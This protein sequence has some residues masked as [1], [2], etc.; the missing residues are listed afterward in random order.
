MKC[1]KCNHSKLSLSSGLTYEYVNSEALKMMNPSVWK[2]IPNL[3]PDSDKIISLNEGGT[4][5]R[6]S[7]IGTKIGIKNLRIKDETRNPTGIFLDRGTATE[8]STINWM[9]LPKDQQYTVAGIL[10]Q[11]IPNPSLAISLAAYSA[12][13]GFDCELFVPKGNEWKL[14]PNSLYQLISYGAKISFVSEKN[15]SLPSNYYYMNTT[16]PIFIA[17]LRTTGFEI[18]D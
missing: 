16:D 12:R 4:P 9:T 11:G 18:C 1:V 2:Y 14:T 7:N 17:G 3:I 8:I 10:S 13:A 15:F 5:L 6:L